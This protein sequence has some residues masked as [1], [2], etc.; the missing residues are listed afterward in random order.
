MKKLGY[1]LA[2]NIMLALTFCVGSV[3]AVDVAIQ[4]TG[5]PC[6]KPKPLPEEQEQRLYGDMAKQA[7][8]NKK[9]FGG[10]KASVRPKMQEKACYL[11]Q[12][13][14]KFPT[15]SHLVSEVDPAGSM[16]TIQDGAGWTI[17]ESHQAVVKNWDINT[18]IAVKPNSLSLWNKITGSR[19]QHKYQLVNLKTNQA[20]EATLAMGPFKHNPYT[21][22]ILRLDTFTGEIYLNNGSSWKVDL[23]GP[24]AE[25]FKSWKNNH[26]I[27]MGM[28][29]TWYSMGNQ[30][31]LIDVDTDNWLPATRLY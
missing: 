2:G 26:Y 11:Y 21:R 1:F 7:A 24:C 10:P 30:F 14:A 3:Q 17:K 9:I 27:I 12:Q 15:I 29:D 5:C 16:I 20:V 4:Q 31:I 13:G 8:V 22:Q 18:P 25:I 23:S 28:N 6:R 19:P